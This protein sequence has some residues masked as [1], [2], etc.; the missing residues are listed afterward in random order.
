MVGSSTS[1]IFMDSHAGRPTF[2]EHYLPL[3]QRSCLVQQRSLPAAG[4]LA[5]V[6]SDSKNLG[7]YTG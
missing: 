3:A 4:I 2:E 6:A 1:S 7:S 5:A